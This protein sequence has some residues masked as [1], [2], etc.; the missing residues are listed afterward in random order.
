M[1][2]CGQYARANLKAIYLTLRMS[3]L[4]SATA[5]CQTID[6]NSF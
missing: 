2:V 5:L 6:Y 1:Y 3:H 4:Y